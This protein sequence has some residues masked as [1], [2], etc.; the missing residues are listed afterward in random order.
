[1]IDP[2]SVESS[3]TVSFEGTCKGIRLKGEKSAA[4][5]KECFFSCMDPRWVSSNEASLTGKGNSNF[6]GARPVHQTISTMKQ[7]WSTSLSIKNS[8]FHTGALAPPSA[9]QA[10]KEKCFLCSP[11]YG[12][13]CRLAMLGGIESEGPKGTHWLCSSRF[14]AFDPRYPRYRVAFFS[15]PCTYHLRGA[16][17]GDRLSGG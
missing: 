4:V 5:L 7:I 3:S 10:L 2:C 9:P 6:Y 17:L 13:A 12:R 16:S 15:S 8:L 11:F 1:M 14:S